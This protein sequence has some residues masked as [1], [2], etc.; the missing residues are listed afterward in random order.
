VAP[1]LT[2][3]VVLLAGTVVVVNFAVDMAY[4][5]LDPRLRGGGYEL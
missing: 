3:L 5:V 1:P 2:E 4:A